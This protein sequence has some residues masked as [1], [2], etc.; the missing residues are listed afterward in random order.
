MKVSVVVPV[1]NVEKYLKKCL[2]SLVNQTLND[3][4]II[5]VNDGSPDNSQV[6]I[7]EYVEM[8]P[9]KVVSVVQDN[10]GQGAARNTGIAIAKGEYIAFVDSDDYVDLCM[11][12]KLYRNAKDNS[13]DIVI[14]GNYV[15]MAS[16]KLIG[17]SAYRDLKLTEHVNALF[18]QTVVWNKLFKASL[19]QNSDFI[20]RSGVWY[21]DSDYSFKCVANANVITFVDEPLYYYFLRE[22]STMNNSNVVRNLEQL[23]MFDEM[24]SYCE[25]HG[26]YEKYFH[27]IEFMCIEHLYIATIVRIVRADASQNLKKKCYEE[28]FEYVKQKFPNYRENIYLNKLTKNKKIIFDLVEKRSYF[29]IK[30][31]FAIKDMIS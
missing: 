13:S 15:L 6:I 26:I 1:W 20:F 4:E 3:I 16:G 28:I 10:A 12:E 17:N 22:G 11:Y 14:C 29:L 18:G 8:Y 7:D 31:I 27:E 2:E 23:Q 21:E 9:G 30:M 24:L 19:I 25:K 5:V